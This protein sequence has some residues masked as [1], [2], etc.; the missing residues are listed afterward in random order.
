MAWGL[1]GGDYQLP[2]SGS[3]AKIRR[4]KVDKIRGLLAKAL[5]SGPK[6]RV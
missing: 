5:V 2:S 4:V 1:D 3:K 6:P